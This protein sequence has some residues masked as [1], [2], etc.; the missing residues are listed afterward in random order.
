M[1]AGLS[2][3]RTGQPNSVRRSTHFFNELISNAAWSFIN[4]ERVS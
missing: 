2:L 3:E 4:T 1:W